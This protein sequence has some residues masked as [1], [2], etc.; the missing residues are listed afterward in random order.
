[1]SHNYTVYTN[2]LFRAPG[3]RV[4][5]KW[6]LVSTLYPSGPKIFCLVGTLYPVYWHLQRINLQR[7]SLYE[8]R[9]IRTLAATSCSRPLAAATCSGHK[10]QYQPLAAFYNLQLPLAAFFTTCSGHLQQYQPLAAFLQLAATSCS[11]HLQLFYNLQR[12]LAA[13][14]TTCSNALEFYGTEDSGTIIKMKK[15]LYLLSLRKLVISSFLL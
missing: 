6:N 1:M 8:P 3:S 11:G 13:I 2:S 12:L 5:M 9:N 14:S 15:K 10:Q 7:A 4:G